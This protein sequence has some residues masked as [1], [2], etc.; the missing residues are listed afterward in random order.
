MRFPWHSRSSHRS[1]YHDALRAAA[2]VKPGLHIVIVG[3]NDGRINDPAYELLTGDLI[4]STRV[5]LFEPQVDVL[6]FLHEN[7]AAHPQVRILNQIIGPEGTLEL[8]SISPEIWSD[9][10][11]RYARGWPLYRAPTGVTSTD[12]DHVRDWA[13]A[14]LKGRTW[15]EDFI[16]STEVPSSGL[17]TALVAN[18]LDTSVDVIQVD[19]EGQDD[20]VL[21]ACD[22]ERLKPGII[23]FEAMHLPARRYDALKGFLSSLGYLVERV[24]GDAMCVRR[25]NRVGMQR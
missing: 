15:R 12:R 1:R 22:L 16:R 25:A 20:A 14:Q 7:Y 8:H 3:A 17:E 6:P 11:P 10:Q 18:G 5:T 19:A 9:V 23:Y 2:S 4:A 24:G 21:K 13:N